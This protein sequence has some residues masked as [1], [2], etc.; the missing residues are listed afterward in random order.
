MINKK[1]PKT[2]HKKNL[3]NQSY[4]FDKLASREPQ[5]KQYL[6]INRYG[7]QSIDFSNA[8]AVFTLNKAILKLYYKIDEYFIPKGYLAAPIP[9]RADYIHHI[10]DIINSDTHIKD[11]KIKILDIGSGANCI[12]PILGV[13]IYN[14]DFT[15]SDID[16]KSIEN[17]KNL[18]S[19]NK[20]LKNKI[21]P[22]LQENIH[23]IFKGVIGKDDKYH[24]T[25]CNPPFHLSQG[26]AI[27]ASK[28][29][30]KNLTGIEQKNPQ[31]NFAGVSNELWCKGGELAF[32]KKMI[33]QSVEYKENVTYFS[34]LVSKQENL[35][36]IYKL[37]KRFEASVKTIQM[38]QG[39]KTTRIVIWSF[40][41]DISI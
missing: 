8:D 30:V 18:I 29:K 16:P 28:R 2:L 34:T 40:Q 4:D 9:G 3:H 10:A 11:K 6:F 39:N 41:Q 38:K 33:K 22:F 26:D 14:W 35:K 37:L 24:F 15:A 12:Y 21:T 7:N 32:I 27:K 36:T 23:H 5:L 25:M 13:A 31:L 20:I 19:K 1:E 17:I